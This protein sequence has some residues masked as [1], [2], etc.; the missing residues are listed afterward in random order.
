MGKRKEKTS[1]FW[2][3]YIPAC[4]IITSGRDF[5]SNREIARQVGV[6]HTAVNDIANGK[7]PYKINKLR[8]IEIKNLLRENEELVRALD[9]AR[10]WR[11]MRQEQEIKNAGLRMGMYGRKAHEDLK[12]SKSLIF[13]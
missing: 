12:I 5:K 7:V 11:E 9:T 2:D 3:E 6:S 8:H 1:F 4:L 13:K 10:K